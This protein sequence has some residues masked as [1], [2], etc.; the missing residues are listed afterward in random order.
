MFLAPSDLQKLTGRERSGAQQRWL[1]A[2]GWRFAV[3]ALGEPV[4]AV[5]EANRHLVGGSRAP[6][7]PD[8][9]AMNGAAAEA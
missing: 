6:R 3:N 2:H 5:A 4:V 7:G 8:W 9:G 1:K